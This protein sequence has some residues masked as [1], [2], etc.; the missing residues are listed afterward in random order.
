V[1]KNI[2]LLA[3]IGAAVLLVV[4]KQAQ[5]ASQATGGMDPGQRMTNAQLAAAGLLYSPAQTKMVNANGDM[6]TRLMGDGW[7]NLT[8]AQNPDGSA[9][10]LKNMFGQVT[11]GDG[12]PVAGDDPIAAYMQTAAGLPVATGADLLASISPYDSYIDGGSDLLGW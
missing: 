8:S 7:R 10:F 9:A 1:S 12:K 2:I 6:W 5:A 3:A 4:R 11:T